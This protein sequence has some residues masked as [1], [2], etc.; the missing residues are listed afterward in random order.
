MGGSLCLSCGGCPRESPLGIR[1]F[2]SWRE[3]VRA[4]M[5]IIP[6][7]HV[8]QMLPAQLHKGCFC[9]AFLPQIS[10][11]WTNCFIGFQGRTF[12]GR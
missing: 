1:G 12:S 10:L 7:L 8:I 3:A 5:G 6:Q 4:Q 9:Q 11:P 2:P